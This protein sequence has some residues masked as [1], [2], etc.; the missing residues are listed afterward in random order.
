MS[1]ENCR[2]LLVQKYPQTL[3]KDWKRESKFLNIFGNEIRRFHNSVVGSVLVD[4]QYR[5]FSTDELDIAYRKASSFSAHEFYFS[6]SMNT[7]DDFPGHAMV[8]LALKEYF[9]KK[10]GLDCIHLGASVLKLAPKGVHMH[11]EMASV[12]CID[13]EL[14]FEVL[15][16][17]FIEAGFCPS[18]KLDTLMGFGQ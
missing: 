6:I 9:D 14:S 5:D 12:F 18:E 15:Q 7:G 2:A 4:E 8:T 16:A 10:G 3:A 1:T 11:E 17:K 13:E